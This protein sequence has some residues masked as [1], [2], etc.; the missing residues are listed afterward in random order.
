MTS[1]VFPAALFRMSPGLMARPPGMFSVVGTMPMTRTGAF[2]AA[3]ARIAHTTAAPPAMSSFM[4]SIPSAGLIEMPPVSNVMPFPTSPSTGPRG[5]PAG[6]WRMTIS[7]GGSWLPRAT[8][9]SRP[10]P[11]CSMALS[12]STSNVR[13]LPATMSPDRR[14]NS[15][16]VSELPG[17]LQ[18]SRARLL[19][20]PSSRPRWTASA[21]AAARPSGTP[22]ATIVHAG[23][24][25]G[26]ASLVLY[27]PVLNSASVR[28]SATA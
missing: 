12:S 11:S 9:R 10:M 3:I 2:S 27:W 1:T 5:A 16:G 17:S 26:G 13:P 21:N 15:R 6:S 8:P 14:A 7:R 25:P 24:V 20:S 19:H 18:R 22:E 28:P 23:A 4:R